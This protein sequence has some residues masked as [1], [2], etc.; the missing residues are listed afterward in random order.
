MMACASPTASTTPLSLPIISLSPLALHLTPRRQDLRA[1]AVAGVADGNR[2]RVGFVGALEPG[3][4]QQAGDHRLD[5]ALLA[6]AGAGD[7]LLDHI[8]GILG[9]RKPAL[10]WRQQ[11][12]TA[13]LPELEGSPRILVD[14]RLLDRRLVRLEAG[15]D[16]AQSLVEL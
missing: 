6:M 4:R 3:A 8:G 7:G 1:R 10:G 9:D 2:Q 13:R 11:R 15:N 14:E 16:P 5:L 12:H